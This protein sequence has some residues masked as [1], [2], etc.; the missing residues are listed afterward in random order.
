[1]T[2]GSVLQPRLGWP[3]RAVGMQNGH[4]QCLPFWPRLRLV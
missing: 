3:G 4:G 1:M 2:G